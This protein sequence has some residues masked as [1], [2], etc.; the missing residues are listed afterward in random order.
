M[1]DNSYVKG[2]NEEEVHEAEEHPGMDEMHY[3]ME[4]HRRSL[5]Q[6]EHALFMQ[7]IWSTDNMALY[8]RFGRHLEARHEARDYPGPPVPELELLG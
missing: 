3:M 5:V 6:R 2:D 1:E 8:E 7:W 4:W